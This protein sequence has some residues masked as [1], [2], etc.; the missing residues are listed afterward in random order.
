[1]AKMLTVA[2]AEL[3]SMVRSK[4]FLISIVVLPILMLGLS[5]AQKQISDRA[6]TSTKRF[7]VIDP[8]GRYYAA[9]VEAA[10]KRDA[11][12][13]A[14]PPNARKP[15]FAPERADVAGRSLDDV[16]VALSERVRKEELFAFVEIPPDAASDKVRYYSDHPAYDDLRDWMAKT[17]D[18][19]LRANR[20]AE[21]HLDPSLVA[22]LGKKVS[23]ET[24]GLW[25]RDADGHVHAAEKQDEVRAVV[26][27][28]AAVFLLFFFV[29]SSAPQLMNSV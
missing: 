29:V 22:A 13:A 17:L 5:F 28:I 18:E 11:D 2:E 6:D 21:A 23:A 24:L 25:T 7:A 26:I 3:R 10:R 1:M 16:R 19:T 4:A 14:M 15:S 20:Y 8:S 12:M 9:V 27:P